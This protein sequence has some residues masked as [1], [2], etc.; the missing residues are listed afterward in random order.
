MIIE[1]LIGREGNSN[2]IGQQEVED[3]R[4]ILKER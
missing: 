1:V 4:R 3:R 2:G